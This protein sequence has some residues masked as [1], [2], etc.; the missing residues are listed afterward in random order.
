[1]SELNDFLVLLQ[2]KPGMLQTRL[3]NVQAHIAHLKSLVESGTVVMSGPTLS[4]HPKTAGEELAVTG[5]SVLVR[6]NSEE[7]VRAFINDDV[8]AKIG[9]WD[10]EK[11]TIVPMKCVVR[12][13]L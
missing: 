10:L 3:N 5:S 1:M 12:K 13:P 7:E 6:A 11:I 9:V 8:Y 4:S 2:D